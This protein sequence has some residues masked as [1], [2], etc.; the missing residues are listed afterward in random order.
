M[1]KRNAILL[2]V[3]ALLAWK[4]VRTDWIVSTHYWFYD[5]D[6]PPSESISIQTFTP[7]VSPFWRPPQPH[8]IEPTAT[9]WR[10]DQ[11]FAM[12]GAWGPTEEPRLH[13]N[14]S[15]LLIKLTC[16]IVAGYLAII[17]AFRLFTRRPHSTGNV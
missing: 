11:F 7:P 17:I 2:L 8:D 6:P 13:I 9:T 16:G 1:P 12:G 3:V 4:L 15:L 14:W 10:H 5:S